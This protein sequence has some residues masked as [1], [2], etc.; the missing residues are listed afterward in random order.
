MLLPSF[1]TVKRW[2][3]NHHQPWLKNEILDGD[4]GKVKSW[5]NDTNNL[6]LWLK[7]EI[8]DGDPKFVILQSKY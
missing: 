5:Y 3:T 6:Q 4:P 7:D 2:Y 8:I 1:R